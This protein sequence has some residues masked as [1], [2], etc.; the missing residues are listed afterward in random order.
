[1][2]RQMLTVILENRPD[3]LRQVQ[4]LL[5]RQPGARVLHAGDHDERV[6]ASYRTQADGAGE[7]ESR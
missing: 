4:M 5:S 6:E 2:S 1:M 3:L 7:D